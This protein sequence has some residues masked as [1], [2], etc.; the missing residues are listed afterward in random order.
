MQLQKT[1]FLLVKKDPHC[2][3]AGK[4]PQSTAWQYEVTCAKGDASERPFWSCICN[5]H[6]CTCYIFEGS[7]GGTQKPSAPF[8][9][10]LGACDTC[11]CRHSRPPLPTNSGNTGRSSTTSWTQCRQHLPRHV[12]TGESQAPCWQENPQAQLDTLERSRGDHSKSK[13]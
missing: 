8:G 2:A 13:K 4:L 7:V 5:P 3:I 6:H 11:I 10:P 1:P 9:A 12:H